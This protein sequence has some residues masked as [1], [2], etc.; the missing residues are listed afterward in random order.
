MSATKK[1]K[2]ERP[3]IH[4]GEVLNE[5]FLKPL[6]ISANRLAIELRVPANRITEIVNGERGIT[7]E[8]ALRLA[9]YFGTTP[10]F[11]MNLQRRYDLELAKDQLGETID[12]EVSPRAA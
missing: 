9:R 5:D 12:R 2:R 6:E 10:E 1:S 11:W 3:P 8:T 7:V 4:P